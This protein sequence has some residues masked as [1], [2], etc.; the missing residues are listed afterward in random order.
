MLQS[1]RSRRVRHDLAIVQQQHHRENS[2]VGLVSPCRAFSF[3]ESP[4]G[5][6]G[7]GGL[8]LRSAHSSVGK[9]LYSMGIL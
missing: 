3:K 4:G 2:P 5:A 8:L 9:S 1:M 6:G 7:G